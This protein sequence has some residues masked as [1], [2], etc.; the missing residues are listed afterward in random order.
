MK[1]RCHPIFDNPVR[2]GYVAGWN[3]IDDLLQRLS[4]LEHAVGE[5]RVVPAA[6]E[7]YYR[8][9]PSCRWAGAYVWAQSQLQNP[10]AFAQAL[11]LFPGEQEKLSTP[12]GHAIWLIL[13][14]KLESSHLTRKLM[15][16]DALETWE[17]HAGPWLEN[18][19][20]TCAALGVA[21]S[22]ELLQQHVR[23]ALLPLAR[24]IPPDDDAPQLLGSPA[25]Y[26][27][28]HG[29][30]KEL[31]HMDGWTP[32]PGL[33]ILP[34]DG[35]MHALTRQILRLDL[36]KVVLL[37][38]GKSARSV[39]WENVTL[40]H[41]FEGV[42]TFEILDEHPLMVAGYKQPEQILAIVEGCYKAAIERILQ[43]LA[44][45]VIHTAP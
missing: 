41:L 13:S 25:A 28:G 26:A 23:H 1:A 18:V 19:V 8:E 32:D 11:A 15:L 39:A 34:V 31:L 33:I 9:C 2:M 43:A 40:V 20:Q 24:D 44:T 27:G 5:S 17:R 4:D 7:P 35:P 37:R 21:T 22:V 6:W 38:A 30:E 42:V 36:H 29:F 12:I 10:A 45:Q 3:S 14:T 16:T